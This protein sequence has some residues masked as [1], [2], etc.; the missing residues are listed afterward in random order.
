MLQNL[1]GDPEPEEVVDGLR[2]EQGVEQ[3]VHVVEAEVTVLQEHPAP[4]RHRL[5][6]QAARVHLLALT[7]RD[8]AVLCTG[9]GIAMLSQSI[10]NQ[11]GSFP[12]GTRGNGVPTPPERVG[13]AFP[14]LQRKVPK[15]KK[16]WENI[17]LTMHIFGYCSWNFLSV[18]IPMSCF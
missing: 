11:Q 5:G 9:N 6:D 1:R 3:L 18:P 13:T 10:Y 14:H 16:S 17:F 12:K 4:L 2:G 8:G 7:H 15:S